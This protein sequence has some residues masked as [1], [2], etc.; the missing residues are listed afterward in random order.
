[1]GHRW[2]P[3]PT[4]AKKPTR[5]DPSPGLALSEPQRANIRNAWSGREQEKDVARDGSIIVLFLASA[6]GCGR[7]DQMGKDRACS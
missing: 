7:D 2:L 6:A 5:V 4:Y 1:M 3:S